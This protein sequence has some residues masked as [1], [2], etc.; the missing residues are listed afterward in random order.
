MAAVSL[1]HKYPVE[2][3]HAQNLGEDGGKEQK[4]N[5]KCQG[6]IQPSKGEGQVS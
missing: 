4:E 6:D 3:A 1:D 5:H 2:W